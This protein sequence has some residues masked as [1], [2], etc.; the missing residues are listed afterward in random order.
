MSCWAFLHHRERFNRLKGFDEPLCY[1][2][3]ENFAKSQFDPNHI[4]Q[5]VGRDSLFIYDFNFAPLN[6][7]GRMSERQKKRK[8]QIEQD[9]GAY[10][11]RAIRLATTSILQ[12]ILSKQKDKKLV[13]LTDEHFQ[14]KRSLIYD[15]KNKKTKIANEVLGEKSMFTG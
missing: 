10:P 6:R 1:D 13:L 9:D 11:K 2:G 14:Y 12:R 3:L 5:V 4:N 8:A 7:K 15:L